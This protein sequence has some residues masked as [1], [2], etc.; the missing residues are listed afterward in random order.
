LHG[1]L[2]CLL[3][4]LEGMKMKTMLFSLPPSGMACA[5]MFLCSC[6]LAYADSNTVDMN[7]IAAFSQR[8]LDNVNF[9]D[10]AFLASA[11]GETKLCPDCINYLPPKLHV[12]LTYV[13]VSPPVIYEG[14]VYNGFLGTQ[15]FFE[16]KIPVV[17]G[18]PCDD[19]YADVVV[20][21]CYDC[22]GGGKWGNSCSGYGYIDVWN[23]ACQLNGMYFPMPPEP[24]LGCIFGATIVT[25]YEPPP[26][27][28]KV[29]DYEISALPLPPPE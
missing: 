11:Y 10:F 18:T 3:A 16:G 14:E 6:V 17:S 21:F 7:D 13:A 5:I 1:K 29:A 28:V 25:T 2:A 8:W 26:P 4:D 23:R 22:I 9:V 27:G 15:G 12:K 20:E 19:N 24:P